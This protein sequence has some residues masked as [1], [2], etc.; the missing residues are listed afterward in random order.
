MANNNDNDSDSDSDNDNDND[1]IMTMTMTV[2]MI[3][4]M[5]TI[6]KRCISQQASGMCNASQF[7]PDRLVQSITGVAIQIEVMSVRQINVVPHSPRSATT[8]LAY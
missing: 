6:T 8:I 5:I 7:A 2:I 4:I 3:M 1:N